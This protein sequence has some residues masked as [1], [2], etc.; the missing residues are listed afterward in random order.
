MPVRLLDSLDLHQCA[1]DRDPPLLIHLST[2]Q[3]DI[4]SSMAQN[5]ILH[6]KQNS[7]VLYYR[8]H[9]VQKRMCGGMMHAYCRQ[10][11]KDH[12]A[13]LACDLLFQLSMVNLNY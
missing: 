1:H 2:D 11:L 10:D 8:V 13:K 4:P 7:R 9:V 3:V 5:L 6:G 12:M